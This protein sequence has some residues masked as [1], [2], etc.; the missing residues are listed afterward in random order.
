MHKAQSLTNP[1]PTNDLVTLLLV[2]MTTSRLSTANLAVSMDGGLKIPRENMGIIRGEA[3]DHE[4]EAMT[5]R[6]SISVGKTFPLA[7][8]FK[9][10]Q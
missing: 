5:G 1:I 10:F 2:A 7:N 9:N 3:V 6:L 4:M 8:I